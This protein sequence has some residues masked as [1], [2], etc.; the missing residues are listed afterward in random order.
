MRLTL[1]LFAASFSLGCA[2]HDTPGAS[3]ATTST[4]PA[5]RTAEQW[6]RAAMAA[7]GGEERLRDIRSIR[8]EGFGHR[9]MLEQSER[10]EGPWQIQYDTIDEQCDF[11][12]RTLRRHTETRFLG[13]GDPF[14]NG[15]S[16]SAGVT[17][18]VQKEKLGPGTRENRDDSEIRLSLGPE[19]LLSSALAA[20]DLANGE[21]EVFQSVPHHVVHFT[22]S[23]L[24][25][26]IH[27]NAETALPTAI[28]STA[29][30]HDTF[31]GVW[32]DVTTRWIFSMWN[33]LPGG[34]RY[35]EQWDIERNGLP[36]ISL[37]VGRITVNPDIPAA[38]FDIP[39]DVAKAWPAMRWSVIDG[40]SLGSAK[41]PPVILDG[42]IVHIPGDWNVSLIPQRD[43]VVILEAP[44]SSDYSAK[45]LDETHRRFP[46][47][48]VKAV[49]STSDSWPHIG[50]LREYAARGIPIYIL[51]RNKPIVERLLAAPHR[52]SPDALAANPRTPQ[53]RVVSRSETVGDGPNRVILYPIH[54]EGGERQIMAYFPEHHLLYGSD[55]VQLGPD[56]TVSFAGYVLEATE[57]VAR[58][59]LAVEHLFSMHGPPHPWSTVLH[60]VDIARS[61]K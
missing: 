13:N 59:K 33:I 6:V 15:S 22:W 30:H 55:L 5:P 41:N 58:E 56:G 23:N 42:G 32:G 51:D 24:P 38:A 10:P 7:M 29:Q 16:F 25:V 34:L 3:A 20:K 17:A 43:G 44:I 48:P 27:F 36:S 46:N 2:T 35:P 19:R 21:D 26:K 45:V 28:E 47:L 39:D 1:L 61:G 4:A 50:G 8:V 57:A 37:A 12:R 60:A 31:W 54:T 53:W 9:N 18:E 40:R 14:K 49:I 11:E 52:L